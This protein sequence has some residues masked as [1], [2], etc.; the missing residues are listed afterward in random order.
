[1]RESR[2]ELE[3]AI[4]AALSREFPEVELVDLELRGGSAGTLTVFV[5]RAG[6]VDLDLCTAVSRA[7][8][9]LRERYALEVSSPGLDRRLRR[10][11]H[12]AAAVGEEV[13]VRLE[14]PLDGR[15]NFRGTLVAAAPTTITVSSSDGV[16]VALPLSGIAKAHVVYNHETDGGHRE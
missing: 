16:E 13:A 14:E 8:E 15:R 12:F 2:E 11:Q 1:M 9:G 3:Q 4:E 6:G 5:D 7:L 10:P